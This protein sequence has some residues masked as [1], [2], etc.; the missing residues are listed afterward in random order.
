MEPAQH[1][2]KRFVQADF[3]LK[4]MVWFC[5]QPCRVSQ[6]FFVFKHQV[7]HFVANLSDYMLSRVSH[8]SAVA[9]AAAASAYR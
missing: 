2:G 6:E 4:A 8:G 1:E 9:I 7:Q 5:L 3:S